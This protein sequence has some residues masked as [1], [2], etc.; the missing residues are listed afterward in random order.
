MT[1]EEYQQTGRVHYRAFVDVIQN[2]L[3]QALQQHGLT[4]YAVTG[5]AKE[6]A[7]LRKKLEDRGIRLDKPMDEIKDLAGCRIVF[8]TNSQ[9]DAFNNTGALHENFEVLNVNVHHPVPGTDTETKLYDSTNY[10]VRLK[11]ER[12]ALA[13]YRE[14]EGF[15]AEIQIQ[16]LLNHAWAEMGHDTIYKE[17]KLTHLGKAR[18]TAIGERMNKVMQDHL[19]PAGHDFDK[20]ARDFRQLLKADGAAQM[21][22]DVIHHADNNNDLEDA[23]ETY[24]DL[25]LP[26]FDEPAAEF[27]KLL[28]ALIGAVERSRNYAVVPIETH[29]G[30][31]PGKSSIDVARRAADLIRSYRY[32]EMNRTF[33]ALLR[34]YLGA[35]DEEERRLWIE[36]GEKLADHNLNVWKRYGPAAQ[37]VILDELKRLEPEDITACRP[38]LVAMLAKVLSADLE[39]TTW[40]SDTVTIHQGAV[41]AS[42]ELRR[43]REES[44]GWLEQWLDAVT[45]DA[46]RLTILRAL[47]QADAVPMRSGDDEKLM[48][49]L[50]EDGAHV[51]RLVLARAPEWGLELRRSREVDALHT[52]YR[53]HVLRPDLAE[54]PE[55]LAAQKELVDALLGLRDLLAADED[56]MLYKTLIGHDSVRPGAWEGDHFDYEATDAWRRGR[57]P[58]IIANVTAETVPEC[59]AR[60]DTYVDAVGNDG[61]HFTPMRE[62]LRL[63]AE[64]KP[65]LALL[66]LEEVSAQRAAFLSGM[67]A[68][69]ERAGRKDEVVALVDQ[70]IAAGQFLPALGDY[71]QHKPEP[72]LEQ[73]RAYVAKAIEGDEQTSVVSAATIAAVWYQRGPDPVLIDT[74]L[75]PVVQFASNH[76]IPHW[77]GHFFTPGDAP[78]LQ[79]LSEQQSSDL[80]QSFVGIAEVDYRAVRLLAAVGRR[81]PQLVIDFFSTRLRRERGESGERFEAV[82]FHPHDLAQVLSPHADLLLPAVRQWFEYEPRFHEYRGGRLLKHVFPELT[83]DVAAKLID[84]ARQG[85]EGDLKFVLKTLSPYEGAE[86][87]YPVCMEVVDR[88]EPGDKLLNKV[89]IVLGE[90]G[91]LSG[92]FGHVEAHA[93]RRELIE[94]Y[95]DDPR[96]RVQAYARDRARELTQYMAWE[97][98]RAAREV[99]QRRRDWNEE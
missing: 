24:T 13:E 47:G 49:M 62:F 71:L 93:L 11:P 77:I 35:P 48:L 56:F 44:I 89:S 78:L 8:L 14:F 90:T 69:L 87:I 79:A 83:E 66:M 75:M 88:L 92:E 94:R 23:L 39:G 58:A 32:W 73:L 29:F 31:Y 25:V 61:G 18:M 57:Y 1:F 51:A 12:L 7:S 84:L 30:A 36:A 64:Q 98:R 5:R 46:E 54:K 45:S 10:L 43:L 59:K 3:R 96:P 33:H 99:A 22:L 85:D 50:L 63:L 97:Q 17:P 20:I 86:Q 60:I 53:F 41:R 70:W 37:Q 28:E 76:Q 82:P 74:V 9:V 19:I 72:N 6:L 16:T 21:T 95:R 15:S 26:H 81:H 91:V 68:G 65:E 34:L 2:I 52:H 80:L 38:L 40:R 67:L 4:A 42:D 27:S 55:L